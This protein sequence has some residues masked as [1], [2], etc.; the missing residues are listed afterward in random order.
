MLNAVVVSI[1][2]TMPA[3]EP[4]DAERLRALIERLEVS[5]AAFARAAGIPGGPSMLSQHM[6]GHRP[7]GLDAGI[8][9]ARGLRVSL[10]EISPRLADLLTEASGL[11]TGGGQPQA[12]QPP[13]TIDEALQVVLQAL[14]ACQERDELR[15]LL[16]LLVT[17]APA[18][19]DRL[20]ELL[21]PRESGELR[22][23][24]HN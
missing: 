1:A 3:N 15:Q 11:T 20:A 17:R 21:T 13:P 4:T 8:A 22:T 2:N 18:Y 23:G 7:I 9:Y 5:Q 24:T 12:T 19:R 6:S 14:D 16:P 10:R